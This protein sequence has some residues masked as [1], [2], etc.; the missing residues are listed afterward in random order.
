M[1]VKPPIQFAPSKLWNVVVNIRNREEI[2][3]LEAAEELKLIKNID[4]HPE[5]L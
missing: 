3:L 5:L 4:I 2:K 1:V